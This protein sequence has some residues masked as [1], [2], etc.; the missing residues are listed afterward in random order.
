MFLSITQD[1][2]EW[3]KVKKEKKINL[4]MVKD[5]CLSDYAVGDPPVVVHQP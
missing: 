2:D 5:Y 4:K 3:W 1:K